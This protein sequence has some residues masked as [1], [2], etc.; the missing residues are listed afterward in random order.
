MCCS[1]VNV[2]IRANIRPSRVIVRVQLVEVAQWRQHGEN[3][4]GVFAYVCIVEISH[5][6]AKAQ[7][8]L[9]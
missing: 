1:C 7:H 9:Y 3:G 6:P 5:V 4:P 2:C 8:K